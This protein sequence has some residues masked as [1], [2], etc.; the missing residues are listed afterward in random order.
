MRTTI[1]VFAALLFFAAP[2][3]A[4]TLTWQDNSNNES[5]FLIESLSGGTWKEVATV[6]P[7]VTTATDSNAEGVYRVRAFLDVND[8]TGTTR[9]YSAYSN[10]AAVLMAPVSLTAK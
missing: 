7:N 8:G 2:A 1:V 10:A 3:A 6:G 9:V 4:V 5:G